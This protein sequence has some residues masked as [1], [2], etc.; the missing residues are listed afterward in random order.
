MP[1]ADLTPCLA[2]ESKAQDRD[3]F[4]FDRSL[5]GFGH[6]FHSSDREVWMVQTRIKG[7]SRVS[8]ST[9]EDWRRNRPS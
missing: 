7:R 4:L 5:S 8:I 9:A 6:C 1:T 2:R 3:S